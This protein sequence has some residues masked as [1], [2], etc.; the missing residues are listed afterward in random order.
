MCATAS[1]TATASWACSNTSPT[2]N[3]H[4]I[5]DIYYSK[6]EE[7]QNLRGMEVPLAFWSS[8]VLQP[9]YT[10]S[11]GLITNAT[12]TNVQ[13]IVPQRRLQAHRQADRHR[14]E[15]GHGQEIRMARHL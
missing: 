1:S 10:T 4:S 14:L 15:P 8:A 13:P 12:L 11:G 3:I 9:G 5:V 2:T 7:N 6:F